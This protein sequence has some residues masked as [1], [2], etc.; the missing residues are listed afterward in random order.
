MKFSPLQIVGVIELKGG[1]MNIINRKCEP[2][3]YQ[4]LTQPTTDVIDK[5]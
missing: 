5:I 4:Q 1:L 2:Q 3:L